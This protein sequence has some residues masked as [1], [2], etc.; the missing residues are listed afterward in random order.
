MAV[1]AKQH[2]LH[3]IS[4]L[5][6]PGQEDPE[7][8]A[9]LSRAQGCNLP[10]IQE[11]RGQIS[12]TGEVSHTVQRVLHGVERRCKSPDSKPLAWLNRPQLKQEGWG[13]KA[14]EQRRTRFTA[15]QTRQHQL[16]Y[17]GDKP[18]VHTSAADFNFGKPKVKGL[19]VLLS[20]S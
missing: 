18:N 13:A 10:N 4:L 15:A 12:L 17:L 7:T 5:L 8:T 11:K 6:S 3:V 1:S 19:E 16:G 20:S 14:T 9:I 2:H